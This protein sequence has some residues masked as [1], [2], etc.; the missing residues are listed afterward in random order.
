MIC[1]VIKDGGVMA[2]VSEK[3]DQDA[4]G[5]REEDIVDVMVPVNEQ[6]ASNET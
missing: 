6:S 1:A 3:G 2:A 5:D 4:P